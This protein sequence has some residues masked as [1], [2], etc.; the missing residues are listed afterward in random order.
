MKKLI[1]GVLLVTSYVHGLGAAEYSPAVADPYPRQVFWGDTHV[2]SNLSA[3]AFI[4]G[5]R[6]LT[7]EH[8]L[9]FARG[10]TVTASNGLQARLNQPLDFLLVS[11]HS[12]LMGIFPKVFARS[13]DVLATELGRRWVGYLEAGTVHEVMMEFGGIVSG[14]DIQA[15]L[16]DAMIQ[17]I[18][19]GVGATADKFNDPG[20]F[21]AFIGYEWTS[22]PGG[23][24]LHRNVL[25][26]DSAD[27]TSQVRPFSSLDSNDPEGLWNFLAKYEADTGGSVMAIPHN[28]N[29]SNGMMFAE[30]ALDGRPIDA[31]Y[32][33][34]R[35][36]FERI[37]EVTQ[38]KGDGEAHP[39]LSPNDEFA[40]YETWDFGNLNFTVPKQDDMLQYEYARSAMQVGLRLQQRMGVNPYRFGMIGSTDSHTSLATAEEDNFYGKMGDSEPSASRATDGY[41]NA[42]VPI[43]VLG[44]ETVSSGYAGVWARENTRESLFDA[45]Q[46]QEVYATTGPRMTVR[47]FGGW[48]FSKGD[49]ERSDFASYGYAHGVPMGAD[50]P[51]KT[52]AK[53]PSFMISAL[54]DA[55]G[56]NLDRIQV[57]KG[58]LDSSGESQ[59]KVFNVAASGNRKIRNNK[60]KAVGNTVD[61]DNASYRNSIGAA[62]LDVV[63]QDPEFNPQQAAFYYVRVLE[64]PTP[65]WTTYDAARL[66]A[67][68][69]DE[70]PATTQERAYT[71][72]IWYQP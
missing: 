49:T 70:V 42:P 71:S 46:R 36:R 60:L 59:E 47:F 31:A 24:N 43:K 69:P 64:I 48:E 50:L 25:F 66:D 35:A 19:D 9:R 30:T 5:N 44:W 52:K 15:E 28:G 11:D 58:W 21:T 61:V 67:P 72:A 22:M 38:I 56:A 37:V 23:N 4:F 55:S 63:W 62:Q 13:K 14:E 68:L 8:A 41:I 1:L 34:L 16:P 32:A 27:K 45:M 40:D 57:V 51:D 7:P 10:E 6:A 53:A 3:D 2:H 39:Y 54:K 12:E 20:K 18:W 17:E 33:E 29:T 26:R 65:R